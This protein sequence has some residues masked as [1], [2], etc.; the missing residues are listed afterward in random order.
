MKEETRRIYQLKVN[1]PF[2]KKGRQFVFENDK[3]YIYAI[4][5]DKVSEYPLRSGLAGY[6]WLLLTEH[7]KYFEDVV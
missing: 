6:L 2:L 5:D 1:L 4:L 3:G 7:D